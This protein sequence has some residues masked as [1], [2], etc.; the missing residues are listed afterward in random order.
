ML[1][2]TIIMTKK[3]RGFTNEKKGKNKFRVKQLLNTQTIQH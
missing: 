3:T 2:R 1:Q